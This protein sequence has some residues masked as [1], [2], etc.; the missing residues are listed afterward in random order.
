MHKAPNAGVICSQDY[1]IFT[2]WHAHNQRLSACSF[3]EALADGFLSSPFCKAEEHSALIGDHDPCKVPLQ[4]FKGFS[5]C[6]PCSKAWSAGNASFKPVI[7]GSVKIVQHR[8]VPENAPSRIAI[9][10]LAGPWGVSASRHATASES[11]EGMT[12][13]R[14]YDYLSF[15]VSHQ[16]V[17]P[18]SDAGKCQSHS[19]RAISSLQVHIQGWPSPRAGP[20]ERHLFMVLTSHSTSRGIPTLSSNTWPSLKVISLLLSLALAAVSEGIFLILRIFDMQEP[21]P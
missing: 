3:T 7:S 19:Y 11:A 18:I 6:L 4:S 13:Q 21:V 2:V 12:Y 14:C 17:E 9:E 20:H 8:I 5:T 16:I 15:S 1:R 10:R